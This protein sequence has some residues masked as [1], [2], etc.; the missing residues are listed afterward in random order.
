M[1]LTCENLELPM[2]LMGHELPTGY[3]AGSAVRPQLASI[4]GESSLDRSGPRADIAHCRRHRSPDRV[5]WHGRTAL[6]TETQVGSRSASR[7][8]APSKT[9]GR[10][11]NDDE[12]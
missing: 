6:F 12:T 10:H 5:I 11:S 2:S 3:S 8:H 9:R 4:A 7:S 1:L